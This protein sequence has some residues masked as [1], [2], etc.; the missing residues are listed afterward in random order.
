MSPEKYGN[1]IH[2]DTDK[3][4]QTTKMNTKTSGWQHARAYGDGKGWK[5]NPILNPQNLTS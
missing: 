2:R 5:P 1:P 4:L 3:N